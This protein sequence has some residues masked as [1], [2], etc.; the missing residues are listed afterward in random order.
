MNIINK[1]RLIAKTAHAAIEQKRKFTNDDY[2][3]HPAD[4]VRILIDHGIVCK[5]T[6]AAA[7]LHD[8]VEDTGVTLSFI[9]HNISEE[10]SKV[11][12]MVT[13]ISKPEDGNR[14]ARKK[15][16]R[17]HYLTADERGM[18]VKLADMI[19]N[20]ADIA[21]NDPDFAVVY[22]KEYELLLPFLKN[23]NISLYTTAERMIE[24]YNA[25][26]ENNRLQDALKK[27]KN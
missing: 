10:V 24:H 13:D 16:D 25:T 11:V 22:F 26:V 7:W 2:I 21:K 1:A 19:S 6:L 27:Y 15:I 5:T 14:A 8:T 17:E 3:V 12:E 9:K 23:G 20:G 4:V 18:N